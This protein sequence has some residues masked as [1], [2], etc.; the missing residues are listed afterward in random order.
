MSFLLSLPWSDIF[1]GWLV[2]EQILA[3]SKIIKANSTLE[4]VVHGVDM[5]AGHF[6]KTKV[7][8]PNTDL[9]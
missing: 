7:P 3:G 9:P 8:E 4:A 1:A 5:V 2:L 6:I